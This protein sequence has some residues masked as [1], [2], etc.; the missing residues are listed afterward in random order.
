MVELYT[1]TL[2]NDPDALQQFRRYAPL[3]SV[4]QGLGWLLRRLGAKPGKKPRRRLRVGRV[5]KRR[6]NI[7][8]SGRRGAAAV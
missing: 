4:N 6:P 1:R 3:S 2:R 5:A 7:R 8:W